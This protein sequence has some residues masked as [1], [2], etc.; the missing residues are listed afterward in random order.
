MASQQAL[1]TQQISADIGRQEQA[2]I[3]AERKMAGQL[4]TQEARAAT[5]IDTQRATGAWQAEQARLG[6]AE[7]AR[8]LKYQKTQ[9]FM[10][11]AA[12]Q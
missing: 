3:M 1:G 5:A 9:A 8:G 11:M 4:Q 10:G 12:G 7:A 6:G 2:N